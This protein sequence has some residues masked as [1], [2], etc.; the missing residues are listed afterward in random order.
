MAK[1]AAARRIWFFG[2][3]SD[4]LL[5]CGLVYV[6]LFA[7]QSLG[8]PPLRRVVPLDL[9]PFLAILLGMPHYGATLLRVYARR[10]DRRRYA[11]FAVWATAAMAVAFVVGLHS[12]P[13]G[14]L[15]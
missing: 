10:E 15:L 9:A 8:G 13:F 6:W 4:A 2:P 3:W 14:S 7:M 12:R 1:A 11:V 5:G